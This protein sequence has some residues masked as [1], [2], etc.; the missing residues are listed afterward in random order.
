MRA[1]LLNE[2]SL[3]CAHARSRLRLGSHINRTAPDF[4]G[5]GLRPRKNRK[6]ARVSG[7]YST[8]ASLLARLATGADIDAWTE[9]YARYREVVRHF[10]IRRGLQAAD[11]DDL[12]QEVLFAAT[13]RLRG[14]FVYD[15]NQGSFRGFLKTIALRVLWR[16]MGGQKTEDVENIGSEAAQDPQIESVWEE[17]WRRHHLRHALAQ[18][19]AEFNTTDLAAFEMVTSDG[20]DAPEV[21]KTLGTNVD[22]VY[23]AKS[24]VLRRLRELVARQT[25][26]EG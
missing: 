7:S 24:R 14:G 3:P 12:V 18:I 4:A 16:H 2:H 1:L 11:A 26:D 15:Q 8:H 23:Q 17:E 6:L 25:A 13:E 22:Q 5:H 19:R 10:A 9:F 21:A 20:L